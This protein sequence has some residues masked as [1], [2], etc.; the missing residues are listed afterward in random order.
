MSTYLCGISIVLSIN[1]L[2]M[3]NC[4]V[5]SAMFYFSLCHNK[6]CWDFLY[7]SF[8]ANMSRFCETS[9]LKKWLKS[10]TNL[11]WWLNLRSIIGVLLF[12]CFPFLL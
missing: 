3:A 2:V 12:F 4:L 7:G 9:G 11:N 5:D 1:V 6:L 8:L 10:D